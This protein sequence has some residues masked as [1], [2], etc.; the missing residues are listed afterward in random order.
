MGWDVAIIGLKHD[1]PVED[2][3]AMA[4]EV[5]RRLN[6]NVSLVF[7]DEY[8]YDAE[9]NTVSSKNGNEVE[10]FRH[11][12]NNAEE[13][14]TMVASRYQTNKIL[15]QAGL[16]RLEKA[17]SDDY[18][19]ETLLDDIKNPYELYEIESREKDD[20]DYL[21]IMIFK[22]NILLDN[23]IIER[24]R[25]WE[26]AFLTE[27]KAWNKW[28]RDYRKKICEQAKSFSCEEVIFCSDQGPTIEVSS[29]PDLSSCQLK[30]YASTFKHFSL[31]DF[32]EGKVQLDK[33]EPLEV[34]FD[35]LREV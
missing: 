3:V 6:R 34:I 12:I 13:Y 22:E 32:L 4:K 30:A 11:T 2:P 29:R 25:T 24:W 18:S 19:L 23:P 15:E 8:A 21:F 17:H 1:L 26:H 5:S 7:R 31:P 33:N 20:E 27:E 14:L 9:S 35:D 28:L 10:L 16:D